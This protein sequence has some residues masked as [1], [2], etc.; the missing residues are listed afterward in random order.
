MV[1]GFTHDKLVMHKRLDKKLIAQGLFADK[2]SKN[3][4]DTIKKLNI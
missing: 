2:E 4:D 3:L 1:F